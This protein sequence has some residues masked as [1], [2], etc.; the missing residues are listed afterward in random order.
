M[1][2]C[3]IYSCP[4]LKYGMHESAEAHHVAAGQEQDLLHVV[5]AHHAAVLVIIRQNRI[6]REASHGR[7]LCRHT[8]YQSMLTHHAPL[9]QHRP[10]CMHGC[11]SR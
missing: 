4:K 11:H 10:S 8:A 9:T 5:K 2:L 6:Q 1:L 7:Q 3:L